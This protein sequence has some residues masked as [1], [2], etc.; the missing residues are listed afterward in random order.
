MATAPLRILVAE[1]DP[2]TL[3]FY[4]VALTRLGHQA[5]AVHDGSELVK[6]ARQAPPDLILTDILMPGLDATP[7][8]ESS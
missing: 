5:V 2:D 8:L 3:H 4:Q 6:R 1:D 7:E